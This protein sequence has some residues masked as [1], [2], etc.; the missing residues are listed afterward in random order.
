MELVHV[1]QPG[2]YDFPEDF[3]PP[4]VGHGIYSNTCRRC[5]ARIMG[6]KYRRT[7]RICVEILKGQADK[8]RVLGLVD[9]SGT[10]S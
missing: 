8:N 4:V 1:I 10:A 3:Q 7:C 5:G 9:K 2:I 6:H